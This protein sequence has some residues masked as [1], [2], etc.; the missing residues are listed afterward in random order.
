[1]A[2]AKDKS[3]ST[4]LVVTAET[5]KFLAVRESAG[6]ADITNVMRDNLGE[7]GVTAFDLDRVKVP[8]GG[9]VAWEIPSL[10]GEA[11]VG[12]TFDGIIVHWREPRSYWAVSL[13]ESGGGSP[14]DCSST[15]GK[16]GVG[17]PGGNCA[18]CRLSQFG[19]GPK[20]GGGQACKQMRLMFVLREDALLPIALFAPPTSLGPLRKYFLRLASQGKRYSDVVTRFALSK[21]TSATG[22]EYAVIDP[23]VSEVL[24]AGEIAAV[25]SYSAGMAAAFDAVQLTADVVDVPQGSP[26]A[27]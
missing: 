6:S 9:G 16:T 18:T 11:E 3:T 13:D 10:T 14:P 22:I 26:S 24:S 25:R 23:S 4:D 17:D 5:S 19:S 15:D 27:A 1:M 2:T 7:G 12:R 21:A 20:G 8:S